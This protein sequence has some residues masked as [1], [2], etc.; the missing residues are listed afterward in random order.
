MMAGK[1]VVFVFSLHFALFCTGVR[2]NENTTAIE[3]VM[4]C[5]NPFHS[6]ETQSAA[7]ETCEMKQRQQ[8]DVTVSDILSTIFPTFAKIM[9]K[10]TMVCLVCSLCCLCSW[11][12]FQEPPEDYEFSKNKGI[13]GICICCCELC[14]NICN[15]AFHALQQFLL[16]LSIVVLVPITAVLFLLSSLLLPFLVLPFLV[17]LLGGKQGCRFDRAVAACLPIPGSKDSIPLNYYVLPSFLIKWIMLLCQLPSRDPVRQK[18]AVTSVK[19][20]KKALLEVLNPLAAH[21]LSVVISF[22]TRLA[23]F[24]NQQDMPHGPVAEFR[25]EDSHLEPEADPIAVGTLGSEVIVQESEVLVPVQEPDSIGPVQDLDCLQDGLSHQ[26]GCSQGSGLWRRLGRF[27]ASFCEE[28]KSKVKPKVERCWEPLTIARLGSLAL[29]LRMCKMFEIVLKPFASQPAS[30]EKEEANDKGRMPMSEAT[31]PEKES[32]PDAGQDPDGETQYSKLSAIWHLQGIFF[33]EF[34]DV[35]S[36]LSVMW[37]SYSVLPLAWSCLFLPTVLLSILSFLKAVAKFMEHDFSPK[38][39][40]WLKLQMLEDIAQVVLGSIAVFLYA[41][42]GVPQSPFILTTILDSAL[43][44][45]AQIVAFTRK[46]PEEYEAML[47]QCPASEWK[48]C[49]DCYQ[50][51]S[52]K[53]KYTAAMFR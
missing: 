45:L 47:Q 27:V 39:A 48:P 46:H 21:A 53:K 7:A 10:T 37:T 43:R 2:G 38:D 6:H 51:P 25:Q 28:N 36:D 8:P 20:I 42:A 41:Q 32:L 22:K 12:L 30:A 40:A 52:V 35:Q 11:W 9:L 17:T 15:H 19:P 29:G 23:E 4:T 26:K 33:D 14:V 1:V 24:Y 18:N 13:C 5:F 16:L 44:C 49:G 34:L 3:R 50:A 31:N